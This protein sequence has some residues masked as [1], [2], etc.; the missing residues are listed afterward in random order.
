MRIRS[1]RLYPK[2]L[3]GLA[4]EGLQ[5]RRHQ[6]GTEG[7]EPLHAGLLRLLLVEGRLDACSRLGFVGQAG[8]SVHE[9]RP[10]VTQLAARCR[11]ALG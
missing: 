9:N 11:R 7:F 6:L 5:C 4:P 2:R 8:Y 10:S 1:R 3:L